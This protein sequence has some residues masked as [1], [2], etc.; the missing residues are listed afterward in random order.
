MDWEGGGGEVWLW[1]NTKLLYSMGTTQS[2]YI[3][4]Q[5]DTDS[6]FFQF[7]YNVVKLFCIQVPFRTS[8]LYRV[9][10]CG[11]SQCNTVLARAS[12]LCVWMHTCDHKLES[13]LSLNDLQGVCGH[14]RVARSCPHTP[15]KSLRDKSKKTLSSTPSCTTWSPTDWKHWADPNDLT[16]V[17]TF[18]ELFSSTRVDPPSP[19]PHWRRQCLPSPFPSPPS[20]PFPPR[21]AH[22]RGKK[23][24]KKP[25]G[26]GVWKVKTIIFNLQFRG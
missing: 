10:N 22:G 23:K 8:T 9:Y 1:Y 24:K 6:L 13:S 17:T 16:K 19:A 15:C 2:C 7:Y 20:F 26:G 12:V 25:S 11:L 5:W 4:W 14:D 21:N 18:S 3:P